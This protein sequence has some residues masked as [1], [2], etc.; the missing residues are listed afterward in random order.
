MTI[1]GDIR[2]WCQWHDFTVGKYY[3]VTVNVLTHP[4]I[5]LDVYKHTKL[6]QQQNQ[7]KGVRTRSV[8][9]VTAE[10]HWCASF[11]VATSW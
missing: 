9:R 7:A 4:D 5:T 10:G 6:Y 2:S 3:K 11:P 1:S 8:T